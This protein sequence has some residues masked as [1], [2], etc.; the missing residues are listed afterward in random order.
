VSLSGDLMKHVLLEQGRT[1]TD[2]FF[3]LFSYAKY[4]HL[5]FSRVTTFF[6]EPFRVQCDSEHLKRDQACTTGKLDIVY[7]S[8]L[9][10]IVFAHSLPFRMILWSSIL[11]E[12]SDKGCEMSCQPGLKAQ[13][14]NIREGFWNIGPLKKAS[15]FAW[16]RFRKE[17]CFSAIKSQPL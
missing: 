7:Q 10:I 16:R 2:I 12:A 11:F 4:R 6:R 8:T 9:E 14:K 5:S 17:G 3:F 15:G 13:A 1:H